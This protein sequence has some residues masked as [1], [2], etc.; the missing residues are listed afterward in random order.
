MEQALA[1]SGGDQRDQGRTAALTAMRMALL[2]RD[3]A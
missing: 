1:R 3:M 2:A